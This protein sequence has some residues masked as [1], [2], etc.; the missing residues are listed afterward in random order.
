MTSTTGYV[1]NNTGVT[2]SFVAQQNP[3]HGATPI[4]LQNTL[5]PGAQGAVFI[6]NSDG[7]GVEGWVQA[8]G[9]GSI[10]QL[11]YDNPVIGSN[12]GSVSKNPG[13]ADVGSG[14]NNTITYIL[15]A[16]SLSK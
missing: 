11:N 5:A 10:W 6:A 4:I 14:T 7:A 9:N 15:N 8:V 16:P 2:L 13:T 12:S 1:T 3:A